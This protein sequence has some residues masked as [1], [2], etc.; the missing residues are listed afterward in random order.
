MTVSAELDSGAD[1]GAE[2]D[3]VTGTEDM[4]PPVRVLG[5]RHHGPGSARALAAASSKDRK[6]VV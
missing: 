5:I 1:V 6:S 3:A 4:R 2:A